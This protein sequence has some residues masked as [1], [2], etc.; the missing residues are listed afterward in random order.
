MIFYYEKKVQDLYQLNIR[1]RIQTMAYQK[2]KTFIFIHVYTQSHLS[3]H[4]SLNKNLVS[5]LSDWFYFFKRLSGRIER[6]VLVY[7]T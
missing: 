2:K 4:F 3:T 5:L 1:T 7:T 6:T